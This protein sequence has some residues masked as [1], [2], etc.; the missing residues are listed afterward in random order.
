MRSHVSGIFIKLMAKI[1]ITTAYVQRSIEK[2][3]N[4]YNNNYNKNS[5]CAIK[6]IKWL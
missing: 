2:N 4:N 6:K 5:L 3:N 1:I